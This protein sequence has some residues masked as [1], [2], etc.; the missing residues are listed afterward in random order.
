MPNPETSPN[1]TFQGQVAKVKRTNEVPIKGL[2][3]KGKETGVI[4]D[5]R[6]ESRLPDTLGY[7]EASGGYGS[8]DSGGNKTKR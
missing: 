4:K 7:E 1:R 2:K 5:S 6:G 3:D 8:R